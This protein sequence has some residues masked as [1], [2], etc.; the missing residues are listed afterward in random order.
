[1]TSTPDAAAIALQYDGDHAPTVLATGQAE[2]AEEILAIARE[3][4]IPIYENPDLVS[5]LTSLSLGDE[6][7]AEMYHIIAEIIAFA[8]YL[9]GALPSD[10][11]PEAVS[12]LKRSPYG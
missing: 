4:N 10:F 8:F 7:P 6:I 11:A 3:H 9:K 12:E 1:M 2:L 5:L